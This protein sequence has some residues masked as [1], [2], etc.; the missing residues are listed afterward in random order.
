MIVSTLCYLEKDGQYLMLLR[1]KKKND[2]NEGKWIAPG[3]KAEPGESPEE[4]VLREVCEETGLTV[5]RLNIRGILTFS[6]E[7]WED[8]YIFVFTAT[9]FSGEI[10][11]C[12]EGELKWIDKKDILSLNLWEGDRIF[13]KMLIE[14]APFFS[15]KLSYKGDELI[16]KKLSTYSLTL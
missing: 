7:G 11:E 12:N 8:E 14:D 15:L 13:L 4:C 16:E 2:V 3:G 10:I 5:G 6:S 9:E 1:N